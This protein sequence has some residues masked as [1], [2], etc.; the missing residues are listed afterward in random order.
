MMQRNTLNVRCI[1]RIYGEAEV[2]PH[3]LYQTQVVTADY[4]ES[5]ACMFWN[6][7]SIFSLNFKKWIFF[8]SQHCTSERFCPE[9]YFS[10]DPAAHSTSLCH[11]SATPAFS[12]LPLSFS[13][14]HEQQIPQQ[15]YLWRHFIS[16]ILRIHRNISIIHHSFLQKTFF[17]LHL[18]Q[19]EKKI[20]C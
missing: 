13:C 17:I 19:G 8:F 12:T 6:K 2:P 5:E 3:I 16:L 10:F 9:T 7:D 14:G 1:K 18:K 15:I 4:S 11:T 20:R